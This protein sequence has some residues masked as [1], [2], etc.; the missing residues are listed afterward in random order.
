MWTD[1]E[2]DVD[3]INFNGL[4]ESLVECIMGTGDR[5]VCIGLSGAWGTGKSSMLKLTRAAI[6]ADEKNNGKYIF[7][8]FNAWLFQGF[9]DAR[10]SLMETIADAIARQVSADETI[11]KKARALIKRINWFRVAK[12][13]AGT[14]ASVA[15]GI[16]PIGPVGEMLI[17]AKSV[18]TDGA[19]KE[20]VEGAIKAGAEAADGLI[21]D[22][23]DSPPQEIHKIRKSFEELLE[24]SGRRLVVFIDDLDRCLPETAISTLE[25]IRLF[26]FAKHTSFIIAAD[27]DMIRDAVRRH[28]EGMSEQYVT[29]YF[30]KLIQISVPVPSLG[31]VESKAYMMNLFAEKSICS[32]TI[33]ESIRT[34]I[35]KSLEDS[36]KG[37]RLTSDEISTQVPGLPPELINNFRIAE[38]LAYVMSNQSATEGNPRLIKRLLNTISLRQSIAKRH[39]I[40]VRED[41]LAKMLLL[42]RWASNAFAATCRESANAANGRSSSIGFLEASEYDKCAGGAA[43]WKSDFMARWSAMSPA[44][45]EIDLRPYVHLSRDRAIPIMG[46]IPLS[47][48]ASAILDAVLTSPGDV[49]AMETRLRAL[50]GSDLSIIV[51]AVIHKFEDVTEWGSNSEMEALVV[52][53]GINELLSTKISGFFQGRPG[54]SLKAGIVPKIGQTTWGKALLVRIKTKDDISQPLRNALTKAGI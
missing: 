13:T 45:A 6:A 5:P 39:A 29:N 54:G 42:E 21:R 51:D 53:A 11:G 32:T 44:L 7:V 19:T 30:D 15:L 23:I 47:G 28:F 38:Q 50:S 14:V 25:A 18:I 22:R 1:T 48:E 26:M 35:K 49:K 17:Q 37:A 20:N 31:P 46:S 40:P 8:E 41:I 9:D 33:K 12:L 16:P 2:T 36:W 3:Y 34:H 52:L 43:D 24:D 4:A 27:T 10:A